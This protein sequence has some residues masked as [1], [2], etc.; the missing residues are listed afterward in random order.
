MDAYVTTLLM[1]QEK[2]IRKIRANYLVRGSVLKGFQYM[3]TFN[4]LLHVDQTS[5][6][7]RCIAKHQGRCYLIYYDDMINLTA[8]KLSLYY[9]R[10]MLRTA[11]HL[12]MFSCRKCKSKNINNLS[13]KTKRRPFMPRSS[14]GY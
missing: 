9:R 2:L 1:W 10:M 12:Y 5:F 8:S 4:P 3:A 14:F 13:A 7:N 6:K 11:G